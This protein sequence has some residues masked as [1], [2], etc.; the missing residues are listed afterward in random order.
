M[1]LMIVLGFMCHFLAS[2]WVF[3]GRRNEDQFKVGWITR[4]K[5]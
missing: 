2:S 3:I 5:D 1:W 4:M